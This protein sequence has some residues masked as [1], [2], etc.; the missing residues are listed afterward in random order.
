MFMNYSLCDAGL[1]CNTFESSAIMNLLDARDSY[2]DERKTSSTNGANQLRRLSR[3]YRKA[4]ESCISGWSNE[5]EKR[6]EESGEQEEQPDDLVHL[7][8]LRATYAVTH[9][10]EIFLLLPSGQQDQMNTGMVD[11]VGYGYGSSD[12]WNLPGGVTADTVRYLRK[13]HYG[14]INNLFDPLVVEDLYELWQPDQH[15]EGN[16]YW[17]MIEAYILWGCL[18]D[19]WVLLSH[20]SIVRRFVKMEG[21]MSQDDNGAFKDYQA[22]SLAEDREGF[23]ALMSILLSA[24]LPGSRNNNSDE[25]VDG[26][27]YENSDAV[28]NGR[29]DPSAPEGELIEGIPTSAYRLWE[30]SSEYG[31]NIHSRTGDYYVSFEPKTAHLVHQHWKQAIDTLP[32]LQR[33][34]QRIPQLNKLLCLLVGNFRD[35]EFNSWQEELCAE[36]LYKNPNIRLMDIN[37]RAA[38]LVQKH[39]RGNMNNDNGGKSLVDEM[40]LNVMRGNAGQVLKALYEFGGGSGA[41][42]PAVMV[43]I[44][45][46]YCIELKAIIYIMAQIRV[47]T[48][49]SVYS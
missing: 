27:E 20:H 41:A 25:G 45:G 14:D 5:L 8:L 39:S 48:T 13:H 11:T 15:D 22:A 31:N 19:A 38:A 47:I 43:C 42:L 49:R 28:Q 26:Y 1:G 17:D 30:T 32:S 33:L 4:L 40:I 18:E 12:M 44:V 10:S 46:S 2:L 29:N 34:R 3:E 23:R 21:Q 7:D 6:N 24:P 36:L 9:L 35:I 16:T 37:V